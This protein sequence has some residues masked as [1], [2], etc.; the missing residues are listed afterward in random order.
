MITLFDEYGTPT[1][2]D[3]RE[4]SVFIGV[5]ACYDKSDEKRIF[6]SV[7]ADMGLSNT[8]PLKNNQ[9]S[10]ERA[11]RIATSLCNLPIKMV[12]CEIGLNNQ[13]FIDTLKQYFESSNQIRV[14]ERAVKER[15][16]AQII[17]STILSNCLFE[18]IT[19]CLEHNPSKK[20]FRVFI[21]NWSIPRSDIEIYLNERSHSLNRS[22]QRL[23]PYV[24]ISPIELLNKDNYRKRFI[25]VLTSIISRNFEKPS[26]PKK[27]TTP[28]EIL[29]YNEPINLKQI[30][31]T[32]KE[33][34]LMDKMLNEFKALG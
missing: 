15:P 29:S 16:I 22:I 17:H 34:A 5:A 28:L 31:I 2:R 26:S 7:K 13:T 6:N 8:N 19:L 12:V 33:I 10:N 24:N 9:I 21:D 27:S 25:D 11:I 32:E 23:F 14:R 3:D 18:V 30:N 1:L 20:E 4:N